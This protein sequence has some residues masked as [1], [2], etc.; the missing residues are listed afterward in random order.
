MWVLPF[1]TDTN[2]RLWD[3]NVS[4][5]GMHTFFHSFIQHRTMEIQT[6]VLFTYSFYL[7][8]AFKTTP[9]NLLGTFLCS[10]FTRKKHLSEHSQ[11]LDFSKYKGNNKY[12]TAEWDIANIRICKRSR[13]HFSQEFGPCNWTAGWRWQRYDFIV[14]QMSSSI[15][16]AVNLKGNIWSSW[17][18]C[19]VDSDHVTCKFC[20]ISIVRAVDGNQF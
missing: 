12:L 15:K 7:F 13:S 6:A 16:C 19:H 4:L 18:T 10:L 9:S 3:L 20:M 1:T 14:Q 17:E 5:W 2:K 11:P 8:F